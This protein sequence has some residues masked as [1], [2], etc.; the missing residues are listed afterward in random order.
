MAETATGNDLTEPGRWRRTRSS[1]RF[2]VTALATL[3]VAVVLVGAAVG[4]V[5][6]QR[7]VLTEQLDESMETAV[8]PIA[9]RL[10]EG[11]EPALPVAAFGDDDAVIQ[12]VG[13]D[14]GVMAAT[15]GSEGTAAIVDVAG[16]AADDEHVDTRHDLPHDDGSF[17]VLVTP[18][19]SP[20]GP[21]VVIAAASLDDV[22]ESVAALRSS[23]LVVVPLVVAAL[24]ALVWWLV[25][26]TLRPV[27]AIQAEVAEISG[28][29]LH[30]RV[31][32]PGTGDEIDRLAETMN[33][34]L[35]RI[36]RASTRQQQ[37][38][39]DASHELRSPLT[40]IRSELEV[41]LAHPDQADMAA[42]HRSVL[43][44]AVEL[45]RL[46]DDLLLLARSDAAVGQVTPPTTPVDLDDVVL[47][48]VQRMRSDDRVQVDAT[49]V[50][51]AQVRGDAGQ[52]SRAVAN[53]TENAARHA[54]SVVTVALREVG[55]SAELRVA[56][57]GPGIPPEERERV[58]ER[59]TRLDDARTRA[60][61]GTGLGLA[62]TREIVER[63]GGT[64]RLDGAPGEGTTVV[65]SLPLSG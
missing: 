38:V 6:A 26:R 17:R 47:R 25:G 48:A 9:E 41:D 54:H 34:M 24:A 40:R 11:G 45:Q 39:A 18:V 50:S 42:T 20:D 22:D 55:T 15:A 52:L 3:I 37:F 30:R 59:F 27:D 10:A 65:I 23:L 13:P 1:V 60:G 57:D 53:V 31:P 21:A 35:D 19:D 14:G 7:R 46:V 51:G 62:I 12:V 28:H 61:G 4:L 63:H 44:E 32:R 5:T 33:E 36:E 56:D 58:F 16:L 49:Q 29:D 8:E 43:D 2:R 64:I